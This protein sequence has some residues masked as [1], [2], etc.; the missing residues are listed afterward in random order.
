[1]VEHRNFG[2]AAD[3]AFGHVDGFGQRGGAF[4][5]EHFRDVGVVRN[6]DDFVHVFAP[7]F[8]PVP[9]EEWMRAV[10]G[11][12]AAVHL[13]VV[14]IVCELFFVL[15]AQLK[16]VFRFRQKAMKKLDV[17]GME[18]RIEIVV[19]RVR[20][21]QHTALLH[22]GFVPVHV[23]EVAG[24][25]HLHEDRIQNGIDVVGRDVRDPGDEDIALSFHGHAVLFVA[26]AEGFVVNE[27]GLAGVA[28]DELVVGGDLEKH[29]AFCGTWQLGQAGLGEIEHGPVFVRE[30]VFV[31]VQEAH[32]A[33]EHVVVERGFDVKNVQV[34][35]DDAAHAFALAAERGPGGIHVAVG[36]NDGL[37]LMMRPEAGVIAE[38]DGDGFVTA[39]HRHQVDVD[40]DDE[41][42]FRCAPVDVDGFVVIGHSEVHHA[43]RIFRVVTVVALG[44]VFLV[45][46]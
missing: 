36:F 45:D 42:A 46:F 13:D 35:I 43:V 34:F 24:A 4:P 15:C 7:V 33:E 17:T 30:L 5:A 37:R 23:E 26:M 19:A 3:V 6:H 9:H 18:R 44:V 25:H 28:A 27:L 32:R 8:A 10:I 31:F 14:W 21:D 40:V 20:Q 2:G 29:F 38:S 39:V 11:V 22:H 1:M 16:A 41:V 12:A